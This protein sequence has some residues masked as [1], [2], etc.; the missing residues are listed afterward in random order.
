MSKE[1]GTVRLKTD[2]SSVILE[3]SKGE[4]EGPQGGWAIQ[5]S[6]LKT[7]NSFIKETI[8]LSILSN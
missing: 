1:K 3:A 6:K 8:C 5:N 4:A 7:H 2:R